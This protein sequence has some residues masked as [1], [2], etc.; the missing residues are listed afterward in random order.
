MRYKVLLVGWIFLA[1]HVLPVHADLLLSPTRVIFEPRERTKT[2]LLK[3]TSN[4]QKSYRV[5]FKNLQMDEQGIYHEV[6]PESSSN[7]AAPYIRYSPRLIKV[8]PKQTQI[9]RI[10]LRRKK[11]MNMLEYRSH[12]AFKEMPPENFGNIFSEESKE[13]KI[14]L[15]TLFE[16]TIPVIVKNGPDNHNVSIDGL[17]IIED[18]TGK[19]LRMVFNRT[20]DSS[21]YGDIT[22]KYKNNEETSPVLVGQINRFFVFHPSLKRQIDI[23]LNIPE[24]TNLDQGILQVHY[25]QL[26]SKGGDLIA[27]ASLNLN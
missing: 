14:T 6:D 8:P 23:L 17:E 26:E 13:N 3:N 25:N 24:G 7:P 9:V 10:F 5:F 1:L 4:Q 2:V 20:G 18:S 21:P 11:D 12:L 27:F 15:I 19:K 22:V 16:L